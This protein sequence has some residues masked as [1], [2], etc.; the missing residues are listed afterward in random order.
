MVLTTQAIVGHAPNQPPTI[1]EI[2]L[3]EIR[4]DEGIVEI[5]AVGICHADIAILQGVIPLPFPRVLG[6]EGKVLIVSPRMP[7]GPSPALTMFSFVRIPRLR[8]GQRSGLRRHARPTWR[9]ST[10]ELQPV[11]AVQQL[12][13]K[14]AQLL[15]PF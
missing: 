14:A 8:R 1:E 3:D 12:Q 11:R 10:P 15:R 4:P 13:P 7:S 2:A 9:Q 5:H 6:H